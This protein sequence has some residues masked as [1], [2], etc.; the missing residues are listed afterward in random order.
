MDDFLDHRPV[1]KP[2]VETRDVLKG[3][4]AFENG[5]YMMLGKEFGGNNAG[6][7][8]R[9][10][11]KNYKPSRFE[12]VFLKEI[13]DQV[14]G[15]QPKIAEIYFRGKYICDVSEDMHPSQAIKA[16][17]ENLTYVIS[18]KGGGV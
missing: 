18:K 17:M 10:E 2:K 5:I 1:Y 12:A 15:K 14:K 9:W 7:E 11:A 13:N 16:I 4:H 6:W 3:E 8:V